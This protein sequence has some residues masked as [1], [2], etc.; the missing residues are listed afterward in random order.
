MNSSSDSLRL[1]KINKIKRILKEDTKSGTGN[2]G[3]EIS[4]E[5]HIS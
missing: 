5:L 3:M 2:G 4:N 1:E